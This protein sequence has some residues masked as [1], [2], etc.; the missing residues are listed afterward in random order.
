[1]LAR[2]KMLV[3]YS[4]VAGWIRARLSFA[5]LRATNLCLRESQNQMEKRNRIRWWSWTTGTHMYIL[6]CVFFGVLMYKC[7]SV[8]AVKSIFACVCI[9]CCISCTLCMYA[10]YLFLIQ[11]ITINAIKYKFKRM[12]VCVCVCVF[13]VIN[14]GVWKSL[15]YFLCGPGG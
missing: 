1:M 4:E 5:I 3:M 14:R 6:R 13:L 11:T 8:C 12:C 10:V 2:L 15:G 9:I 7:V